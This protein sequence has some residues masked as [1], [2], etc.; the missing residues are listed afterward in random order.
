VKGRRLIEGPVFEAQR[1]T[2]H[3]R[4]LLSC[5]HDLLQFLPLRVQGWL[6]RAFPAWFLPT[7]LIVKEMSPGNSGAFNRE[8]EAYATLQ[9]LQGRTIP[10]H[11]GIAEIK[12][13][14]KTETH[15]A[16]LLELVHGIPLSECT[17][18]QLIQFSMEE[19]INKAHALLSE[20]NVVHGDPWPRHFIHT[21]Q[22]LRIIDFGEAY[23]T[24]DADELNQGDARDALEWFSQQFLPV[25]K[26]EVL[27]T[28]YFLTS[29]R[30]D[31]WTYNNL[32]G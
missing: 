32:D 5:I 20:K 13:D 12:H 10:M 26:G 2:T 15:K 9:H 23:V 30:R 25:S 21:E 3:S 27:G 18:E 28:V 22:G 1:I 8:A 17:P 14:G 29:F 24:T 7:T 19:K 16:H 6:R 31:Q 11:Y 4:L